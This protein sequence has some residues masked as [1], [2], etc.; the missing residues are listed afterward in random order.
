L[1]HLG[2]GSVAE[3]VVRDAPC[4]VIAMRESPATRQDSMMPRQTSSLPL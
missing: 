4:R 1:E 2:M 3:Q